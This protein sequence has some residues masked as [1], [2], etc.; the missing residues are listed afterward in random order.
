MCLMFCFCIIFCDTCV[1][2]DV[3]AF[4][5]HILLKGDT[6]SF[7]FFNQ[8]FKRVLHE[9]LNDWKMTSRKSASSSFYMIWSVYSVNV[10]LMADSVLAMYCIWVN[11]NIADDSVNGF[12]HFGLQD[13]NGMLAQVQ[14]WGDVIRWL[15]QSIAPS[16]PYTS[17]PS[18]KGRGAIC[19]MGA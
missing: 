17:S 1:F 3:W 11:H 2:Y 10:H 14:H 16:V 13:S 5:S 9:K 12:Y 6:K 19:K 15:G 8:L 7:Q 4:A 18:R